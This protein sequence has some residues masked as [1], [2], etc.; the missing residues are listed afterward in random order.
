MDFQIALF[1]NDFG[2]RASERTSAWGVFQLL[3]S[4]D[5]FK[6]QV[7]L[8]GA[9]YRK[10]QVAMAGACYRESQVADLI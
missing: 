7:A 9:C 3:I 8:A 5:C 10:D 1:A 2:R 4:A 6:D